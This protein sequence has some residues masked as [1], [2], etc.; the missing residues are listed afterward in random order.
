MDYSQISWEHLSIKANVSKFGSQNA[1]REYHVMIELTDASL[2]GKEQFEQVDEAIKR[3]IL[4]EEFK[5]MNLVWKRYFVSDII[6]QASFFHPDSIEAISI[7]QQPPLNGTKVSL[8]L[9]FVEDA[10]LSQVNGAVVMKRPHYSHLFHTQLHEQKGDSYEQTN[11]IVRKYEQSLNSFRGTLEINC[12]RTWLFVQDVDIQYQGMVEARRTFFEKAGL[13]P[14]THFIAS[15]GIEGRYIYPEVLVLMD[16]Y[17]ITGIQKEQIQYLKGSSHLNPTHEY[18]VTFERGTTVQYGDRRHVFI[19]GTASINNKGEIAHHLDINKQTERTL[20]N[21][22]VLLAEAG[23][24]MPDVAHLI[25]YL[26][27]IA[28]YK[29]VADY[30]EQY[31]PTIPKV[32]LLAPVCRPGWLVEI[33]CMAITSVKDNRFPVF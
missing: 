19:S 4:S 22:Q 14:Q 33:E 32:I 16:A 18:G 1:G 30:L 3:L 10:L 5:G 17:A 27:D 9:Y 25:V 24:S 8:W 20:E 11:W 6:N 26:R 15:T 13:T 28:D 2:N 12:I 7:I 21:I 23:A 31:Y 29:T